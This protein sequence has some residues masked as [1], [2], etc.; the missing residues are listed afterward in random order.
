MFTDLTRV[1]RKQ[2]KK[3]TDSAD[4]DFYLGSADYVGGWA[5]PRAGWIKKRTSLNG[6]SEFLVLEVFPLLLGEKWGSPGT[7]TL[8]ISPHEKGTS[9]KKIRYPF[10]VYVYKVLL[11]LEPVPDVLQAEQLEMV[12]WGELYKS[13]Q[14][15]LKAAKQSQQL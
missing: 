3:S 8:V 14:A 13:P 10:P 11:D 5:T 2:K 1:F 12:A 4:A 6:N 7:S 9:F 15:A